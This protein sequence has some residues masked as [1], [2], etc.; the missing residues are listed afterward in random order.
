MVEP[1]GIDH[2]LFAYQGGDGGLV[3]HKAALDVEGVL[4]PLEGGHLTL[5]LLVER[6]GAGDGAHG[7]GA[8][9]VG[10][11]GVLGG[12]HQARIRGQP[13]VVVGA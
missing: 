11:Q 7:G 6:Q 4:D 2:I 3:G 5:Q 10:I 1:V 13:Q 9:A 8:G 12:L